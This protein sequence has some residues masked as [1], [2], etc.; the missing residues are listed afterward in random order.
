[1]GKRARRET[2]LSGTEFHLYMYTMMDCIITSSVSEVG[3]MAIMRETSMGNTVSG[4]KF[5]NVT[6]DLG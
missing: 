5:H 1:M 2:Y 4:K 3:A 6:P